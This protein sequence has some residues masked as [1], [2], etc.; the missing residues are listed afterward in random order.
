M[1]IV[2]LTTVLNYTTLKHRTN[3]RKCQPRL[4]TVLNYTTLKPQILRK[5]PTSARVIHNTAL[6]FYHIFV[7][8]SI[9]FHKDLRQLFVFVQALM[10]NNHNAL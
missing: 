6:I 9:I 1:I 8:F 5:R 2:S 3:N 10:R 7:I 4:T